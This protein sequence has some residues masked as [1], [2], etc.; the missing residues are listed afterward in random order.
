MEPQHRRYSKQPEGKWFG[1]L[2][3]AV[4]TLWTLQTAF[5]CA[6][7]ILTSL[8]TFLRS[9]ESQM[10]NG[11]LSHHTS[12]SSKINSFPHNERTVSNSTYGKTDDGYQI[13]K[14]AKFSHMAATWRAA[15]V[16]RLCLSW[17]MA[18]KMTSGEDP[19]KLR[20]YISWGDDCSCYSVWAEFVVHEGYIVIKRSLRA[21][22][23]KWCSGDT[24]GS[25]VP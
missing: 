2:K 19:E 12:S 24:C 6:A 15:A 8:F 20:R 16:T 23:L 11:G 1:R 13:F 22:H 17:S 18:S 21:W 10:A 14:W 4:K 25:L 3:L 5:F 7:T 9:P